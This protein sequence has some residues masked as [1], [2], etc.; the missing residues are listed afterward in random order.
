MIKKNPGYVKAIGEI[1]D[2]VAYGPR[3]GKIDRVPKP[4][5]IRLDG[6]GWAMLEDLSE[7]GLK[8]VDTDQIR[9]LLYGR[10]YRVWAGFLDDSWHCISLFREKDGEDDMYSISTDELIETG[11]AFVCEEMSSEAPPNLVKLFKAAM[12]LL[13]KQSESV[14]KA[15]ARDENNASSKHLSEW[16]EKNRI[17]RLKAW[18]DGLSNDSFSYDKEKLRYHLK[19]GQES[20]FFDAMF[21]KLEGTEIC[22]Y[23]TLSTAFEMLKN[24]SYR[25]SGLAGMNDRSEADLV[26]QYIE[27]KRAGKLLFFGNQPDAEQVNQ[28]FISSCTVKENK[29]DLTMFRLYGDDSQGV[30]LV[31]EKEPDMK[32][33]DVFLRP[34][35]YVR[36][37]DD[38]ENI[39]HPVLDFLIEI[40]KNCWEELGRPFAF[41]QMTHMKHFF[42]LED[43]AIEKEVRLLV[44]KS[45][46]DHPENATW[47]KT[48]THSIANPVR[49]FTLNGNEMPVNVK[50]II[51]GPNCP[52]KETNVQQLEMLKRWRIEKELKEAAKRKSKAAEKGPLE[53]MGGITFSISKLDNYRR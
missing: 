25:I 41:T 33:E 39:F 46:V 42:K 43:Y 23:S 21:G 29:D 40:Y 14:A 8:G 50:E 27:K 19:E 49:D 17:D 52:E 51:L 47:V 37:G 48:Y 1:Q 18:C 3:S 12:Q 22:R 9:V 11:N 4:I 7:R 45:I 44:V 5:E 30:C 24:G 34:V 38:G 20:K 28:V 31:L 32:N 13:T 26:Y 2:W 10:G 15:N 6:F 35:L 53:R 36:F 16:E